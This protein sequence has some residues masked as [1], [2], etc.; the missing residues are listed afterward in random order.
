M[1]RTTRN[2]FSIILMSASIL[3]L[4]VLEVVWIRGTWQDARDDFRKETSSIFRTVLLSMQDTLIQ[5]NLV[6]LSAGRLDRPQIWS[7]DS[8]LRIPSL[9][10]D[11]MMVHERITRIEVVRAH[12]DDS[13]PGRLPPVIANLR[14]EGKTGTFVYWMG[15]DSLRTDSI[16][17]EFS[18]ALHQAGITAPFMIVS[19]T[20]SDDKTVSRKS[21]TSDVVRL[22]PRNQY[23]VSFPDV[24]SVLLREIFPQTLFC[25][26]LTLLTAG[27]FVLMY[28]SMRN[29]Q[30]LVEMKNDFI[31][32]ITHELKTPVATVS[33][34]LEAL[35]NF[36][37]LEDPQRTTEYLDIAQNELNRLTLMTDKILKTAVFEER[38]VDIGM[39]PLRLDEVIQ[40]VLQSLKVV[41]E[42]GGVEIHYHKAGTHFTLTGSETHL[43]NVVF[44]L[45]DNAVKYGGDRPALEI[46]L[47]Q[48]GSLLTLSVKDSGAGIPKEYQQR[49]FEKFFRVP[50]GDVHNIRGYGLGLSYVASVVNLHGGKITVESD[51][52][53]GSKFMIEL[54][55]SA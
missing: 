24:N 28:R 40:N 43:T 19:H 1:K 47:N 45:I 33:V 10:R 2:S 17:Q 25:I 13:I 15:T 21:I 37:A 39:K 52:G 5:R 38:G 16:R 54:P 4:V 30:R 50:S 22:S 46:E 23:A 36:R 49:I 27:S 12:P 51:P 18:R 48:T 41:F 7:T 35:R 20:R 14:A 34:A 55:V 6:P 53:A 31:S 11:T 3:L 42:K 29:Q 26:F 44:N 8:A 9:S 32:N